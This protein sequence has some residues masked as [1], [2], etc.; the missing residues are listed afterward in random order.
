MSPLAV[1]LPLHVLL[2]NRK[3]AVPYSVGQVVLSSGPAQIDEAVVRADAIPV[4]TLIPTR[5]RPREG[6]EHKAV[7]GRED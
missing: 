2:A 3:S 1:R 5:T 7:H 6:S 4:G